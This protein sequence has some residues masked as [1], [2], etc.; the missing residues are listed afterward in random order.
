MWRC[1]LLIRPVSGQAEKLY[2]LVPNQSQEHENFIAIR[3]KQ[4]Y[5]LPELLEGTFVV[6]GWAWKRR[7]ETNFSR[8]FSNCTM[9]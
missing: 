7:I 3:N 1:D 2:S 8:L 5:V 6:R 9:N 4:Y